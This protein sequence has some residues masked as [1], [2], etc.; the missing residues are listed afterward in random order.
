MNE[1]QYLV[2]H[3]PSIIT[4]IFTGLIAWRQ[5]G[6]TRRAIETN[7]VVKQTKHD[8][9][10]GIGEKIA[11]KAVE[12]MTPV[13]TEA[14]TVAADRIKQTADEVAAALAKANVWNGIERRVGP[15]DRRK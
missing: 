6:N 11:E 3:L 2:D 5:A 12:H 9:H 8:I 13:L 1:F 14:A 10:N 15:A 7:V 4:A